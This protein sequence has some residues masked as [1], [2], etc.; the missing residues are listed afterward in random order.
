MKNLLTVLIA[1]GTLNAFACSITLT[2]K[3][4]KAKGATIDGVNVSE[5]LQ[6]AI[7][8]QCTVNYKIMSEA[9]RKALTIEQL[10]KRLEKLTNN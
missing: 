10:K 9:E 3:T 5:K 4:E 8:T 2:K 7:G 6:K 1:L